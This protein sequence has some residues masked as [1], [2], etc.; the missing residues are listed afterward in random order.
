MSVSIAEK[1]GAHTGG[2]AHFLN[3]PRELRKTI[4][5]DRLAVS[6]K[7]AGKFDYLH[8]FVT[9]QAKLKALFPRLRA[10][11]A[12]KGKAWISWPKNR[13][14]DTD[15]T[16][17]QIIKIGYDHGLVESKTISLDGTWSALKFTHPKSGKRYN[18]KYGKLAS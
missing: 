10:H 5:D 1:L 15:L 16:L 9:K 11:L 3:A 6:K 7:F 8:A 13:Q 4:S 18:N 14:L 12:P 2:R 17:T